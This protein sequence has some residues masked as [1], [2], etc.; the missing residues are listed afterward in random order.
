[1]SSIFGWWKK[2][3]YAISW[4]PL[5]PEAEKHYDGYSI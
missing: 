5:S 3:W 1:M 2:F 4:K